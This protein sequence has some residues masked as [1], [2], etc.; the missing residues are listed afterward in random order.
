MLA[1]NK[2]KGKDSQEIFYDPKAFHGDDI[3]VQMILMEEVE[4]EESFD[5]SWF[6]FLSFMI[7]S[8]IQKESSSIGLRIV[9]S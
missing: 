3:K 9:N 1:G 5:I 2:I 8:S 4:S 7:D 6:K